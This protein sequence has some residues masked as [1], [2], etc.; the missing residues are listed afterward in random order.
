MTDRHRTPA[1][2]TGVLK[3]TGLEE[4]LH[5]R[6]A[7]GAN[8]ALP[9]LIH[10]GLSPDADMNRIFDDHKLALITH[11]CSLLGRCRE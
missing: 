7:V 6:D 1:M 4:V 10:D 5:G 8:H 2:G 11:D 3:L 9:V